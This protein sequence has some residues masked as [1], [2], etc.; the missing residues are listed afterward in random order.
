M[1]ILVY[2][3]IS[4]VVSVIVNIVM[5]KLWTRIPMPPERDERGGSA[6]TGKHRQ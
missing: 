6:P 5:E 1:S 2:I 3:A 4:L